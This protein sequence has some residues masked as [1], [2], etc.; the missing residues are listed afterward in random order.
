MD[1]FIQRSF[2]MHHCFAVV[3]RRSLKLNPCRTKF[4]KNQGV[5]L[6]QRRRRRVRRRKRRAR[7]L[8]L[9][10]RNILI[11]QAVGQTFGRFGFCCNKEQSARISVIN[12][13]LRRAVMTPYNHVCLQVDRI[14]AMSAFGGIAAGVI[15]WLGCLVPKVTPAAMRSS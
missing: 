10:H 4:I 15:F 9:E 12:N 6:W 11:L 13:H 3:W 2:R 8:H 5:A 1:L 7:E 14:I